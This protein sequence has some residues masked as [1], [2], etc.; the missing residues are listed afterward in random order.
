MWSFFCGCTTHI[1]SVPISYSTPPVSAVCLLSDRCAF[2]FARVHFVQT[3]WL[4]RANQCCHKAKSGKW[5]STLAIIIDEYCGSRP[6]SKHMHIILKGT[7]SH[8]V[9]L[10]VRGPDS[11]SYSGLALVFNRL[12]FTCFVSCRDAQSSFWLGPQVSRDDEVEPA[13]SRICPGHFLSP[14]ICYEFIVCQVRQKVSLQF[15]SHSL[16]APLDIVA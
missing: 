15:P 16:V 14:D 1:Q 4:S 12:C 8:A 2:S 9:V 3:P 6:S 5:F 13:G 11:C 10:W 7:S